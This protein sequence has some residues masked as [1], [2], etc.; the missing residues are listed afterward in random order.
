MAETEKFTRSR[1]SLKNSDLLTS[2]EKRFSEEIAIGVRS[3]LRLPRQCRQKIIW[4]STILIPF[5]EHLRQPVLAVV[6][7]AKVV[8]VVLVSTPN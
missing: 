2:V 3:A 5:I 4:A 8:L 7:S 1:A 6:L